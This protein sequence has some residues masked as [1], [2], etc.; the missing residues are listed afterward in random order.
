M[1]SLSSF[2][3]LTDLTHKRDRSQLR[4][5]ELVTVYLVD[6]TTERDAFVASGAR[7]RENRYQDGFMNVTLAGLTVP[8]PYE[9]GMALT[10]D[11]DKVIDWD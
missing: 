4:A 10:I 2:T 8:T 1:T 3:G 9:V 5:G 11:L 6:V 7:I